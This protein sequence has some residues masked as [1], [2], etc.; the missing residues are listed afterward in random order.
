MTRL[1]HY[2][3]SAFP[4]SLEAYDYM[5]ALAWRDWAW[6]GLRRNPVYQEEAWAYLRRTPSTTREENEVI[7]TR[8]H[9]PSPRAE[10]WAL[11]SFR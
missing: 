3:G 9:E 1:R 6:E 10:A 11:H 5:S 4:P 8:L 7:V 2:V